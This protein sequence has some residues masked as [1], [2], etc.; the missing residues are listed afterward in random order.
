MEMKDR[1]SDNDSLRATFSMF[2]KD[3]DGKITA[4]ELKDLLG[5]SE[6]YKNK[7]EKFWDDMIR[8]VDLNGDGEVDHY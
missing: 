7:P 4:K 2:D 3:G 5:S 8:E 1:F 6:Q